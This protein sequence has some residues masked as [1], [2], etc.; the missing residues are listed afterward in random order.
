M[1]VLKQGDTTLKHDKKKPKFVNNS[2]YIH[3]RDSTSMNVLQKETIS[4]SG[5]FSSIQRQ[6]RGAV[7]FVD[8]CSKQ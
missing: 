8:T 5:G 6:R 3:E 1:K 7:P 4:G 2:F